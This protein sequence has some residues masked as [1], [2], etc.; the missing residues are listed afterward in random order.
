MPE[1]CYET[2]RLTLI[3]QNTGVNSGLRHGQFTHVHYKYN[4][5]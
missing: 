4:I 5:G 3:H 1:T 2:A